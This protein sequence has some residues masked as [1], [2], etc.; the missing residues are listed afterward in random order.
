MRFIVFKDRVKRK[1][2]R[3]FVKRSQGIVA[4]VLVCFMLLS[5]GRVGYIMVFKGDEYREKA[6][7]NQL[8]DQTIDAVRGTIYDCNMTP[9]V[10]STSAWILCA[11]PEAI[12]ETFEDYPED[13]E[14]FYKYISKNLAKIL[15]VK[16]ADVDYLLRETDGQYVRIKKKV[17]A[18]MRTKI[19]EFLAQKYV[20]Q[21][22]VEA[23]HFWEKDGYVDFT[24]RPSNYFYYENDSIRTY[25]NNNFAS[26]VIG[27][28]NA[29]NNGDTG[30]ELYYNDVL[31]GEDGRVVTAKDAK[32]NALET[33]YETVF[34]AIEGNG[35]VLT[36]D[37][38]I[39]TYL[40]N[41]L[42]Q[43]LASTGAAGVYGIVM[44]VDTGAVLA[45]SDK[46]D[47]DLNNPRVLID[48]VDT[49]ELE[50][51]EKGTQEYSAKYSE[52]LFEQW[53]SF[54]VTNNY[55]PGSTFKIFTT[56]AALEEGVVNLNST[57]YC[58]GEYD[59]LGVN[60]HCAN[61]S[62]HGHQT[63]TQGL[64]NS[65]NP[66]FIEIGQRLGVETYNKYFDAFGFNE[67]TGI[68]VANEASSVVHNPDKMTKVDLASTSFGQSI[69]ITP[70]QLITAT[71]AIANGGKLMQPYL[72]QSI[73]DS[74]GNIV[75]ETEPTVKRRV[76]SESTAATVRSMM[77]A[78]VEGGTGKN[79]YIAGYRV[80]GKTATAEKLDDGTDEPVYIASFVCF[81]PADDPEVA[82]LVGVD[83]PPGNY[84]GGGVL[85]API[86]K[87]VMEATLEYLNVEPQYTESELESVSHTTP[88][89]VGKGVSEAKVAAAGEGFTT[90][91]VG[92]GEQVISQVPS[93]GESIPEN[94]VIVIYTDKNIEAQ[95][96]EVPDFTG[97]SVSQVNRLAAKTGLNVVFSGPT[98]MAGIKS[99]NQNVAAKTMVEAGSRVTVYFRTDDIAID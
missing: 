7:N 54:C 75:S 19:E 6:A 62:G 68:D 58:S 2:D 43:A 61:L 71:C 11:N 49:T 44:D 60:Y 86:A 80:A 34:D 67:K 47:F 73:I 52:L 64:M 23:E 56:A 85:A 66:V 83:D 5:F 70:L 42:S 18:Q 93:A 65:C 24:V 96:V 27:V 35:V 40:E 3:S 29:D 50:K 1:T 72:V 32:G 4:A 9:L 95:E 82:I 38:N 81:A 77:E 91:V 39:Q 10:T 22:F 87:E 25:P 37:E 90:R 15:S 59:V 13:L 97:L 63:F 98:D 51:L 79:A 31:S 21:V 8:Y 69:R 30:I 16:K 94:G 84:R 46:P 57:F 48:S 78:V 12:R 88:S 53:N 28:V 14:K 89:L 26:T 76:I 41:A 17:S 55:E 36:M 20:F 92:T 99:Y 74:D 33:G 45:M